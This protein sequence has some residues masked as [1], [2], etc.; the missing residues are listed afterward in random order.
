MPLPLIVLALGGAT[1]VAH[2]TGI[3]HKVARGVSYVTAAYASTA[4]PAATSAASGSSSS[5][6]SSSSDQFRNSPLAAYRQ[7]EGGFSNPMVRKEAMM[8]LGLDESAPEPKEVVKRHRLLMT[9]FHAD[10]GGSDLICQKLNQ[11]RDTVLP[12]K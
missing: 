2:K 9:K 3:L 10:V 5:Q 7:H 12:P 1:F 4:P 11:A 8:M 6:G